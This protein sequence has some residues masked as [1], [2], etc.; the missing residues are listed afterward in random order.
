MTA[1]LLAAHDA[2]EAQHRAVV[3]DHAHGLVDLVGLA[4]EADEL[5][6]LAA[7]ARADGAL[8]LV[9][10]VDVQ[11][12]A[13]VEGDVVGH[14]DQR[15]DG[16]QADGLQALLHPGRRGSVLDAPDVAP[17]EARAGARAPLR[18]IE[19]DV[20]R[21]VVVALD[22]GDLL[23]RLQLAEAGGGEIAGD[24]AHAR[25]VGPVGRQL[26]LDDGIVEAHHIDVALAELAAP[27]SGRAR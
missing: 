24:A 14:V 26:H 19:L 17:G 3:G 15:V 27:V 23:L 10:I 11:R 1:G 20:D 21:A 5:L 9:G 8:E 12:P 16:P 6:T 18:E 7:E 22:A 13:A 4:V 25:A 2:A